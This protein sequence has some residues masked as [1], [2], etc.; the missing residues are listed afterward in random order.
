VAAPISYEIDGE[1]Y[2]AVMAG[3]G[4]AIVVFPDE[5]AALN[6]YKNAGRIISFKL[7][8]TQTPLP[9]KKIRNTVI[10][11]PPEIIFSKEM[12]MKGEKIYQ[13]LCFACHYTFGERHFNDFPDLSMLTKPTHES[14]NDIL[15]KGKLSYYGMANFSDVLKQEEA[16]AVH[17]Y[18]ISVQK[19]RFEKSRKRNKK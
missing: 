2:V 15:L 17:Q 6:K 10:P 4:G 5:N 7:N 8:G 12:I 14:F 3:F 1:Q 18:L 19:E 9:P 13:T 16:E 11:A